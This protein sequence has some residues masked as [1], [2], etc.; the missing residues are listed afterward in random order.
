MSN[1]YRT[2]LPME[3][4]ETCE[5]AKVIRFN[6]YK[7]CKPYCRCNLN[8]K[9]CKCSN[10][11]DKY[12]RVNI[13]HRKALKFVQDVSIRNINEIKNTWESV[14]VLSDANNLVEFIKNYAK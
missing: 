6:G 11:C 10:I 2:A 5:H 4:C 8:N 9:R 1:N 14:S 3:C 13:E 7:H 12:E